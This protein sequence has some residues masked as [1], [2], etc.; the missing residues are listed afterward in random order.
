MEEN[1]N[2][3][4]DTIEESINNGQVWYGIDWSIY[5]YTG[6]FDDFYT[7]LREAQNQDAPPEED[8]GSHGD[9]D[10]PH[11]TAASFANE[12]PPST[13]TQPKSPE[14]ALVCNA[15]NMA[16]MSPSPE[17]L[18]GAA[19]PRPPDAQQLAGSHLRTPE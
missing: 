9:L 2:S 7:N 19:A 18:Y 12:E 14:S 16:W 5:E 17:L 8:S 13:T 10:A 11:E 1:I 15:W 3:G 6:L 4:Q